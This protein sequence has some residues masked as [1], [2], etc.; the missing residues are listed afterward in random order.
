MTVQASFDLAGPVPSGTVL[1]EASAGTGKTYAVAAIATRLVVEGRIT[2]PELLVVTFTRTAAAEIRERI[3]LR[4]ADAAALLRG[5]EIPDQPWLAPLAEVEGSELEAR[6]ERVDDALREIDGA[7]IS[8]IHGFCQTALRQGGLRAGGLAA[9][10]LSDD[11][12]TVEQQVVRDITLAALMNDI[13]LLGDVSAPAVESELARVVRTLGTN[14]G[15]V[16]DPVGPADDATA[17]RW[18]A[19][20]RRSRA[21][22][23]DRRRR[24][25]VVAFDDLIMGLH[26]LVAN[27]EVGEATRRTLRERYRVVMIDE[28]QDTDPV[29]WTTFARTFIEDP[30]HIGPASD[31]FLVGDPKQAIYQFRGADIRAYLDAVSRPEVRRYTLTTNYRSDAALIAG[32]NNILAGLTFGDRRVPYVPV[33]PARTEP[34]H[35]LVG[36]RTPIEI[37]WVPRHEELV[38][39]TGFTAAAVSPIIMGDFVAETLALLRSG[40]LDDG[41]GPRA[42]HPGDIAVLTRSNR[43]AAD[44]ADALR[45]LNIPVVQVGTDSVLSTEAANQ[46]ALLLSAL[47]SPREPGL[48]GAA[49]LGWF[50][51]LHPHELADEG[52][53]RAIH[54][55]LGEWRSVFARSGIISFLQYLRDDRAVLTALAS[56]EETLDRRLTDLTHI[57]ELIDAYLDTGSRSPDAARR[58][59]A[60]LQSGAS[61][62]DDGTSSDDRLRR[63]ETDGSSVQVMTVH[64]AKGLEFPIVLAPML[65]KQARNR[66]DLSPFV[67]SINGQ[68]RVD[69]A[70]SIDW[71]ADTKPEDRYEAAKSDADDDALR[72]LYVAMTRA[73]HQ[74]I[75]WFAPTDRVGTGALARTL[76]SA[77]GDDGLVL[78]DSI[79]TSDVDLVAGRRS[80]LEVAGGAALTIVDLPSTPPEPDGPYEPPPVAPM[81]PQHAELDGRSLRDAAWRRWSYS[82]I[83]KAARGDRRYVPFLETPGEDEDRENAPVVPDPG[84]LPE[85]PGRVANVF[86]TVV[87]GVLEACDFTDPELR[88]TLLKL[89]AERLQHNAIDHLVDAEALTDGLVTVLEAPLAPIR[90]DLT[91]R[92]I[93]RRDRLA[94][95]RFQMRL[96]P[97]RV[98][99]L[100][101]L[102]AERSPADDPHREY[103]A[104]LAA[105]LARREGG[106]PVDGLLY[107]EIDALFRVDGRFIVV[108]YKTNTLTAYDHD[109]MVDGMHHG[110]Y[111]LQA[112]LYAIATH[113]YLRRRVDSY[114]IDDHLL[115]AAYLFVRGMGGGGGIHHWRVDPPVILA[116]DDYLERTR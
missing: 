84:G 88:A 48:A 10:E 33:N 56:G 90:T 79:T 107:G 38:G 113:R 29:Q 103:F 12:G 45:R 9:N 99:A 67:Y 71:K 73:R 44:I 60:Q 24:Q 89:A 4:L 91:L 116:A 61:D 20:A 7:S 36:D 97:R 80:G 13:K 51:A 14:L 96:E 75:L 11:G 21:L 53:R 109:A 34:T 58:A 28:F 16:A 111:P 65:N 86:G 23:A 85:I 26:D 93:P 74:L 94:E 69:A 25:G 42:V 2:M 27:P 3:R 100:A 43:D 101:A 41:S 98:E 106:L 78:E 115:G 87:H 35:A 52:A 68:R 17:T 76:L 82:S 92:D 64:R 40:R 72:L 104:Q 95:L 47:A 57:A 32:L 39:K 62:R 54:S 83:L 22:I 70:P 46:W 15:A 1:L 8:T 50:F 6:R 49:A 63:V 114:S 105:A 30:D 37:R 112:L 59:L 81:T 18:A 5:A 66:G 102:V 110:N 31:V 108:D 77:R 19:L 55:Q